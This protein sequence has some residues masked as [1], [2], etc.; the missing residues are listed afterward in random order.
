MSSRW[1]HTSHIIA[2]FSNGSK[3][4]EMGYGNSPHPINLILRSI[5]QHKAQSYILLRPADDYLLHECCKQ[6]RIK[7]Q[8]LLLPNQH[9]HE[10]RYPL[11]PV[12]VVL[13]PCRL[14]FSFCATTTPARFFGSPATAMGTFFSSGLFK[15]SQEAKKLLQSAWKIMRS[16]IFFSPLHKI[17]ILYE[18]ADCCS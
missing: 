5:S 1:A 11:R 15:H 10:Q 9:A 12:F 4:Q 18:P 13:T 3:N 8:A 6:R 2:V 16:D 14:V 17:F 7:L